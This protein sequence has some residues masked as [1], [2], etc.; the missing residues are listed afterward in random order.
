MPVQH[1]SYIIDAINYLKRNQFRE[2]PY[3]SYALYGLNSFG[4]ESTIRFHDELWKFIHIKSG[5]E[6][7]V[8]VNAK[9]ELL[10]I[11]LR[12]TPGITRM[13]AF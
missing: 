9:G 2:H 1:H 10:E 8:Y 3:G 13:E 12:R 5:T 4:C 6:I 7:P 11:D